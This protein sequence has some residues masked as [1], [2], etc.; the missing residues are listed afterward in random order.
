MEAS[1]YPSAP[2]RRA[3]GKAILE[4]VDTGQGISA[5]DVPHI[6]DRFY[7]SDPA[8]SRVEGVPGSGLGLSI[9]KSIVDALGGAIRIESRLGAGARVVVELPAPTRAAANDVRA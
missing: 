9:C 8:R 2:E 5:E 3:A 6:F 4:V 7:R 1:V